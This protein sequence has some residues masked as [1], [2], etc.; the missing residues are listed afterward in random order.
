MPTTPTTEGSKE[1]E[2]KEFRWRTLPDDL[3]ALSFYVGFLPRDAVESLLKNDGDYA[4]WAEKR[5]SGSRWCFMLAVQTKPGKVRHLNLNFSP[6]GGE[7][8]T[9]KKVAI[10]ACKD[11]M[12][13]TTED[14]IALDQKELFME[15]K[16]LSKLQHPNIIEFLGIVCF[17]TP[18]KIVMEFCPGGKH[19]R[20][21]HANFAS[22]HSS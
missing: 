14:H 1:G 2:S 6:T 4:I 10:K 20:A 3:A 16:T 13:N 21:Q 12:P 5:E 7:K 22:Q 11:A 18:I 8:C 17:K 15:A 9:P 19:Q